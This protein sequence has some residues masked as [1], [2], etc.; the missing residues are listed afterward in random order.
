MVLY[1]AF[2]SNLWLDQMAR[3]CPRSNYVGRGILADYKWQINQRGFANVI[4]SAGS[5]V[6]GLVYDINFDDEEQLDRN[7]GV[8]IRA[9]EKKYLDV[10]LYG[11]PAAFP[12]LTA[13]VQADLEARRIGAAH[14]HERRPHIE[15][16]V[17]VYLST[18]HT[19]PGPPRVEYINR[20]NHGIHD[21]VR[22]GVP[23]SYFDNAV[24]GDIPHVTLTPAPPIA[25]SR[26][27]RVSPPAETPRST[28]YDHPSRLSKAN[29]MARSRTR[30][31][32]A[33]GNTSPAPFVPPDHARRR[34]EH[35]NPMKKGSDVT[36]HNKIFEAIG[37]CASGRQ[38][39]EPGIVDGDRPGRHSSMRYDRGRRIRTHTTDDGGDYVHNYYQ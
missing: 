34:R 8:S 28:D 26:S 27:M 2:G 36:W 16:N 31:N 24:R 37:I 20:I 30:S 29:P 39:S 12:K 32:T 38:Y 4:S 18:L 5:C 19:A 10:M 33:L 1:F 14:H 25:K 6:H 11:A 15:Q 9:Y 23:A 7:E 3:R 21:S 35:I 22:L 13:H 17:L